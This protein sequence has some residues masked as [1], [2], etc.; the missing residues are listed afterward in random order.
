MPTMR[1]VLEAQQMF[2]PIDVAIENTV[3]KVA[4][5]LLEETLPE[6]IADAY[7]LAIE[8]TAEDLAEIIAEDAYDDYDLFDDYELAIEE[9]DDVYDDYDLFDDYR[10]SWL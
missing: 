8:K 1:E 4:S 5:Y 3:E 7:E 9:T 6:I 2:D 10:N